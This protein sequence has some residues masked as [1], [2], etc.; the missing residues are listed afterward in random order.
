VAR[1]LGTGLLRLILIGNGVIGVYLGASPLEPGQAAILLRFGR[2]VDTVT[3]DGLHFT[4]PPPFVLRRV[5]NVGELRNEDFGRVGGARREEVESAGGE[6]GR[7][8]AAVNEA[9]MQTSDN[10]IVHVSFAVQYRIADPYKAL[11]R[12]G[13][14]KNMVRS[15]A[16]A[17]MRQ[18]TGRMTV[19]AVL[20]E[21][22]AALTAD[23]AKL[24]QEI[25]E[26]YGAGIEI[27][28][29]ELQDVQPPDEV[30][31]AFDDVVAANQD[32]NR[33]MNEAE[34]YRN[35]VLPRARAEAVEMSEAAMGY[36]DAKIAEATG[37]AGRFLALVT[38]YRKAPGVTRKRLYLETMEQV[39]PDV[40]KVIIDSGATPVLPYL[41][42]GRDGRAAE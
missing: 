30:R 34:G 12:V 13:D 26:S 36:R 5:V 28:A 24:L 2:H 41:P 11:Y 29:V 17:A 15:A 19:D 38:E 10:N 21:R 18:V 22:R 16:A 1:T 27:Q 4:L 23:A 32:A 8:S 40:E 9:T 7:H 3:V 37:E 33:A 6:G 25:L 31:A 42:L 14:L 39:L 35:E 20:R